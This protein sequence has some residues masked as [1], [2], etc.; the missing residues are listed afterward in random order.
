HGVD[1]RR[2]GH[3]AAPVWWWKGRRGSPRMRTTPSTE[4]LCVRLLRRSSRNGAGL[5]RRND[6]DDLAA[7]LDAELDGAAGQREQR[8]VAATPDIAAGVEVGAALADDDLACVDDLA[9]ETLH[10]E[11]LGIGI[12]TVLGG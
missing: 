10:A 2:H 9:A 11:T 12:A 4:V 5:F 3:L 6:V 8:V 7:A 1:E